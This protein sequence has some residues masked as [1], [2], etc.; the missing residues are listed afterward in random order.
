MTLTIFDPRTGGRI[1]ITV[2]EKREAKQRARFRVI[3]ELDRWQPQQS[4]MNKTS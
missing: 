1:A 4:S 2:S 3:R